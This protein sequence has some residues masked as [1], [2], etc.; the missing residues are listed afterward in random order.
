MYIHS[1]N[2]FQIFALFFFSGFR[3]LLQEDPK[4]TLLVVVPKKT[5]TVNQAVCQDPNDTNLM[6]VLLKAVTM[7]WAV[8]QDANNMKL[9]S[10]THQNL[11]RQI[12]KHHQVYDPLLED[13]N[14]I[15]CMALIGQHLQ[16]LLNICWIDKWQLEHMVLPKLR[17]Q[18]LR[19]THPSP[20]FLRGYVFHQMCQ[21]TKHII[22]WN[23]SNFSE[24]SN[25]LLSDPCIIWFSKLNSVLRLFN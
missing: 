14:Q 15:S 19:H 2:Y 1:E 9:M 5:V 7:N 25:V 18:K 8:H 16:Q 13:I 23:I 10:C 22:N 6:I 12:R 4:D 21:N 24:P 3:I 17:G 11:Q 20:Q